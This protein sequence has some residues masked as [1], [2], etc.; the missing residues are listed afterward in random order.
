ME[1]TSV[2]QQKGEIPLYHGSGE[3]TID[4]TTLDGDTWPW[5]KKPKP[6]T[7]SE[8][9]NPTTKI[10]LKWVVNSPTPTWD[11]IGFDPQ[12]HG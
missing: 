8:H 12:P 11:A 7:P 9:P 1:S 2:M 6:E 5:V 3:K 10:V 4:P